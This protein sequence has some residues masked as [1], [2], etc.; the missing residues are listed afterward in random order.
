[1]GGPQKVPPVSPTRQRFD[2]RPGL[3]WD[4]YIT[5][6]F[7]LILLGTAWLL[8]Q[9]TTLETTRVFLASAWLLLGLGTLGSMMHRRGWAVWIE[10]L[11]LGST[12]LMAGLLFGWTGAL[13]G[14]VLTAIALWALRTRCSQRKV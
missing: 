7:V 1:M 8:P 14:L 12:P 6:Q 13:G 9:A 11:R 10:Q 4:A 5:L 2:T 3:A